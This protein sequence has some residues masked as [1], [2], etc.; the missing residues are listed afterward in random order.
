MVEI[1]DI[2]DKKGLEAWLENQPREV[3]VWIASRTAAR[4]L[5]IWWEAARTEDWA[6][7]ADLTALQVLRSLMVSSGAAFR[8]TADIRNA[9]DAAARAAYAAAESAAD[10]AYAAAD[11]AAVLKR[12]L[13]GGSVNP[14]LDVVDHIHLI[15]GPDVFPPE[16]LHGFVIDVG[17]GVS[18]VVERL[19][20]ELPILLF[21]RGSGDVDYR[22]PYSIDLGTIDRDTETI[23]PAAPGKHFLRSR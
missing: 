10:A 21:R 8:P 9:A 4:V 5:P 14:N 22:L 12:L 15:D 1:V 18:G 13:D 17:V 20:E 16:S 7:K 3:S 23:P 2:N 11:D 6:R 19:V